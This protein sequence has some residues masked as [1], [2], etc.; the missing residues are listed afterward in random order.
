M[1]NILG[2]VSQLPGAMCA[3][4]TRVHG[5]VFCRPQ[6]SFVIVTP[7]PSR[8]TVAF[9]PESRMKTSESWSDASLEEKA[10]QSMRAFGRVEARGGSHVDLLLGVLRDEC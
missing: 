9:T 7:L 2:R 8:T 3:H 6:S 5:M 10:K 4:P 1:M